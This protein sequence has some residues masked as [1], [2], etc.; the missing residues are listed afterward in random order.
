[1]SFNKSYLFVFLLSIF[2]FLINFYY[3][4]IG[5]MPSDGFVLYNGGYRVLN[6][7]VPFKDYW[8]VT[9]PLLDYLNALFFKIG[10]VS[11][12]TYISHS[13]LF[14]LIISISTYFLLIKLNLNKN[15]SFFYS[16]LFSL[17]MYPVV[18]T[19]FVDHHATIFILIAYY[20]LII[21]IKNNNYGLFLFIPILICLSFLSKQTPAAYALFFLFL[22]FSLYIFVNL[23]KSLYIIKP[24]IIGS[25]LSFLFLIIFFHFTEIPV[26]NFFDQYILFAKTI[27]DYRIEKYDFDLI[28]ILIQYKF[29]NILLFI[30]VF[31]LFKLSNNFK[32]N[33]NDFFI[34]LSSVLLSLFLIFHQFLT[35][36]QNYIFF[37]IPFIAAL[38]HLYQQKIFKKNHFLLYFSILLCIYSVG[39]YH[40]RFNEHRKFNELEKVNLSKA[41]DAKLLHE[42]LDGLKWITYHYPE[43]PKEEIKDLKEAMKIIK[44][45]NN[46]KTIIT[47][48]QFIAPALS[49]YDFSP[50]QW[51]HATVSFPVKKQKYFS[52]YKNF[53][54][55][56]LK[57]NQIEIIYIIGN[58]DRDILSLILDTNCYKQQVVGNIVYK[59]ILLKECI[60]FQ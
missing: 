49:I 6:G 5:V 38:I 4:N 12:K 50:N 10:G 57:K 31:I 56:S 1:M 27:G 39:K 55:N 59:N 7:Y 47:A 34:I 24:L 51:H 58:I 13:S 60:D 36:N 43:N 18:G 17:M 48:Y 15:F 42:S 40:V 26:S 8:L 54:I 25:A 52:S 21:G 33:K 3:A 32:K 23:D 20:L 45:D 11:W 53:F 37:L 9:G 19:P 16:I 46:K 29:I 44:N 2:S 30:L 41:V 35:L 14:N 22:I 28:N